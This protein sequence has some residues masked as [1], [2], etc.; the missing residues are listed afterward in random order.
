MEAS[1]NIPHE[2]KESELFDAQ[3]NDLGLTPGVRDDILGDCLFVIARI[4][5]E[6]HCVKGTNLYRAMFKLPNRDNVR[7]WYQ[8]DGNLITLR[9][10]EK[11]IEN[12]AE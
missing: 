12:E 4:P 3:A 10:I 7:I 1:A 5:T 6:F 9:A 8:F 11:V 2:Y